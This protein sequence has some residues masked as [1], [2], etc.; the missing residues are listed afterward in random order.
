M[1]EFSRIISLYLVGLLL[2]ILQSSAVISW[3][4]IKA[5]LMLVFFLIL[6]ALRERTWILGACL[7]GFFGLMSATSGFWTLEAAVFSAVIIALLFIRRFLTGRFL[8]DFLIGIVIGT[9]LVYYGIPVAARFFSAGF[10]FDG[11]TPSPFSPVLIEAVLNTVVG[12]ALVFLSARRPLS[13]VFER[14]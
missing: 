5:D 13:F 1:R 8:P 2:F 3:G 9:A 11:F 10:D 4:A 6:L 7:A 14:T 12:L